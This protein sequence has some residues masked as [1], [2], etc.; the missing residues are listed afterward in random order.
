M[1]FE[2]YLATSPFDPNARALLRDY[3]TASCLDTDEFIKRLGGLQRTYEDLPENKRLGWVAKDR[4]IRQLLGVTSNAQKKKKTTKATNEETIDNLERE[5]RNLKEIVKN[6][7]D[8][9]S[10]KLVTA[11]VID[12]F[13]G[14]PLLLDKNHQYSSALRCIYSGQKDIVLDNL[15]R[16]L[17]EPIYNVAQLYDAFGSKLPAKLKSIVQCIDKCI[18]GQKITNAIVAEYGT[19]KF[20]V[21]FKADCFED[22]HQIIVIK[23]GA[24]IMRLQLA[25]QRYTSYAQ[26]GET[27]TDALVIL[28]S[29]IIHDLFHI[30]NYLQNNDY[31]DDSSQEFIQWSQQYIVNT[32]CPN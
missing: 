21:E 20:G 4:T 28:I 1:S 32:V 5:V 3:R 10:Q 11:P 7:L 29:I 26:G 19:F 25:K 17:N 14:G 8:I 22:S 2:N 24:L 6:L 13:K 31:G 30:L 12:V 18:L 9:Q 27:I 16:F 23:D 15:I